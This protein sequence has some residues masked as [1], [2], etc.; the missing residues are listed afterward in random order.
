MPKQEKNTT[1]TP[2][3]QSLF[4]HL[5]LFS[6]FPSFNSSL[7]PPLAFHRINTGINRSTSTKNNNSDLFMTMQKQSEEVDLVLT[8]PLDKLTSCANSYAAANGLQVETKKSSSGGTSSSSSYQCAPISLLPNAFPATAF[9]NAKVLAPYF[10]QLVDRISRDGEFLTETLAGGGDASVIAKDEYTK[11]LL[12]LYTAIYMTEGDSSK[13][14]FAKTA[15]RLGIQ[16]SDYMLNPI[17]NNDDN[18]GA[19]ASLIK[20]KRDPC[21]QELDYTP[22]RKRKREKLNGLYCSPSP[23]FGRL[24]DAN[25]S[26][27]RSHSRF[28]SPANGLNQAQDTRDGSTAIS[29]PRVLFSSTIIVDE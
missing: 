4:L 1:P 24:F 6:S 2:S 17:M 13:A 8:L 22:S 18:D 23:G 3:R 14:N 26:I 9:Q 5:L 16:R 25:S 19:E 10:N 20:R 15:D 7:A 27:K 28:T 21:V 11:K 12:E 29:T